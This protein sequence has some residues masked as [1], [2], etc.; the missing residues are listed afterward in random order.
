MNYQVLQKK[1][2]SQKIT[3]HTGWEKNML[4]LDHQLIVSM[5]LLEAGM[6]LIMHYMSRI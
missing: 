6:F 5:V 4:E 2:I 1:G 3:R